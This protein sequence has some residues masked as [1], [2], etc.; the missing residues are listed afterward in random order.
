MLTTKCTYCMIFEEQVVVGTEQAEVTTFTEVGCWGCHVTVLALC[1][2]TD[3]RASDRFHV[4]F[5]AETIQHYRGLESLQ[6]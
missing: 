6:S 1:F 5:L 4:V 3:H 2:A